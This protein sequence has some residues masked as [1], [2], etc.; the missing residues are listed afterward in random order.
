M[1]GADQSHDPS[2]P[3]N[4]KRLK[5]GVCGQLGQSCEREA[6]CKGYGR[7]T[8]SS[9]NN[10]LPPR[11]GFPYEAVACAWNIWCDADMTRFRNHGLQ[12]PTFA[13]S[14]VW[15]LESSGT[16]ISGGKTPIDLKPSI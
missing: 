5:S 4:P 8:H 2:A 16:L 7:R 9:G 3:T 11:R 10:E 15:L 12:Y 6:W 13:S 14:K 1:A